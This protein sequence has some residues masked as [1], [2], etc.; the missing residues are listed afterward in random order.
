MVR[1]VFAASCVILGALGSA[2]AACTARFDGSS[3]TVLPSYNPFAP[4]DMSA[5]KTI[6][7][8]NLS[9]EACR[10]RVYFRRSPTIAQ[11]SSRLKYNLTD[12]AGQ[13][14]LVETA[15]SSVSRFLF[16]PA[17]SGYG[18]QS[19]GFNVSVERGQITPPA[20]HWDRIEL[21][22]SSEDGQ[23]ELARR[24]YYLWISV[25]S[26]AMISLTGGGVSTSVPFN[27]LTTGMSRSLIL[28]AKSNTEYTLSF[29]SSHGGKLSL[30]PPITGQSWVIPY[31]MTVDG[32]PF[33]LNGQPLSLGAASVS[34]QQSHS[35]TFQ[36]IDA[37]RK[38][39]GRY[40]DVITVRIAPV[41]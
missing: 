40:K 9:G 18:L 16:P 4:T 30:D 34:G 23:T 27:T 22:L 2:E 6:Q 1:L 36:I 7:V 31:R 11:F 13:S 25:Q 33:A 32:A 3:Y 10:Y 14:L 28:E 39:A 29:T 37:D 24:D 19:I 5:R 17:L 26:I 12:D 20:L 38:R 41:H 21:V 35:L 15:G 8:A